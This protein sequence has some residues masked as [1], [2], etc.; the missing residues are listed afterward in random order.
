MGVVI[1]FFELDTADA[2]KL[3]NWLR[4]LF[5]GSLNWLLNVVAHINSSN[6][7]KAVP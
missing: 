7:A 5:R 3:R 4:F 2:I 1:S 6:S